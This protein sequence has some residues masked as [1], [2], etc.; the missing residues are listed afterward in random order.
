MSERYTIPQ[1]QLG[2]LAGIAV[3]SE[4][5]PF[6]PLKANGV[7]HFA[8]HVLNDVGL[9]QDRQLARLNT[10]DEKATPAQDS[11][12]IIVDKRQRVITIKF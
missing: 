3:I 5:L 9:L 10:D 4:I 7:V 6:T 2:L 8:A 11:L 12:Q 1:M